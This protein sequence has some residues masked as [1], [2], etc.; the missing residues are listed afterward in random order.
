M[1]DW[2]TTT[3]GAVKQNLGR[4]FEWQQLVDPYGEAGPPFGIY[5]LAASLYRDASKEMPALV[6][7]QLARAALHGAPLP[8]ALIA[9]A[10]KRNRAEGGITHPR[11]A[12][13][14]AVLA[15]QRHGTHEGGWMTELNAENH[16]P[17][18]LCGRLLA[19]LEEIQRRAIPGINATLVDRYFGTASSAPASVSAGC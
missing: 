3:V 17:A 8:E 1:R 11:A 16:E 2:L 19:E 13:I 14:K 18:Y 6:P 10:L 5:K 9:Q 15:S 7:Q 12:L 4:W